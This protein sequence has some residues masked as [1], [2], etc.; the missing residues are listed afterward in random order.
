MERTRRTGISVGGIDLREALTAADHGDT[1]CH[2]R[3]NRRNRSCYV[4]GRGYRNANHG[5]TI[6]GKQIS[7]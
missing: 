4:V 7:I 5:V 1:G 2:C 3:E 6:V